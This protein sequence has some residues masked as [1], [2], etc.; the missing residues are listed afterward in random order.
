[1]ANLPG[2]AASEV[3]ARGGAGAKDSGAPPHGPRG[4]AA[5]PGTGT[6]AANGTGAPAEPTPAPA[7]VRKAGPV[8]AAGTLNLMATPGSARV[9]LRGS[10]L[11][12]TPLFQK[13]LPAGT[14]VL[15][16]V[17]LNGGTEQRVSVEIR[18]GVLTPVSVRLGR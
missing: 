15:R 2:P 6:G 12:T 5:G 1:M 3:R 11:G 7:K 13:R 9:Y 17:P 8:A 4:T 16:L 18:A 10:F 14:H